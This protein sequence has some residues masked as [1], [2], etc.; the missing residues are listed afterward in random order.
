MIDLHMHSDCS[1]G[2]MTPAELVEQAG[3]LGLD[4]IALTDHDT[5]EGISEFMD[6][7]LESGMNT[8]PGVEISIDTKLPN[9]GHFH[10]LGLFIDPNSQA[11]KS[12]LDFLREERNKRAAKIIDALNTLGVSVTIDELLSE[13]GEGSIGRPHV[14]KILLRNGAVRSIQEA[15][16][17]YLAK[18]KP[19]YVDKTKFGEKE[20]LGLV[21]NAG[22]LAVLAH[23]HL[24]GY[25][26]SLE[27]KERI[28]QIV[29]LG[30]DGLETYYPS[31]PPPLASEL[32]E[33]ARSYDLA[34]SGG[35]DFHGENKPGIKM[36]TGSGGLRIAKEVY[37]DLR[38][39]AALKRKSGAG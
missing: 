28:L 34:V 7:G 3:L 21:K 10:L 24:M 13:A 4:A 20:A 18:G 23:P 22:G 30:L 12:K 16:D 6:A 19:A 29:E 8:I 35:S 39:R 14:A 9:N 26:D 15:F 37:Y 2:T 1:D 17:I 33:F 31:M 11:L 38:D 36:G 25:S 5:V 27:L 32:Q